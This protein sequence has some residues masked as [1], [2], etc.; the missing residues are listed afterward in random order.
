M[1]VVDCGSQNPTAWTAVFSK[2]VLKNRRLKKN[3][4]QTL[5]IFVSSLVLRLDCRFPQKGVQQWHWCCANAKQSG[6]ISSVSPSCTS[7]YVS[8]KV[9]F[10]FFATCNPFLMRLPLPCWWVCILY[11]CSLHLS[12]LNTIWLGVGQTITFNTVALNC[13][14]YFLS[15]KPLPTLSHF[16]N[17]KYTFSCITWAFNYNFE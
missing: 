4:L 6:I 11:I 3:G 15:L 14:G 2:T 8:Q 1:K 13:I 12:L 9:V 17:S 16:K 5:T 10:L 7:I